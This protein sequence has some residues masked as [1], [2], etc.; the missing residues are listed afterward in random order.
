M[1]HPNGKQADL[2]ALEQATPYLRSALAFLIYLR[3]G[4]EPL[5]PPGKSPI[6]HCYDDA[7]A[8]VERLKEDVS[9]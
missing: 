2:D 7:D 8:F 9:K 4:Q 1:R 5:S 3:F 6:Q